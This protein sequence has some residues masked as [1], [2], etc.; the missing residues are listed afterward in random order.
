MS[1]DIQFEERNGLG[2]ITLT[3]PQALNALSLNMLESMTEHL[4]KWRDADHI[5]IVVIQADDGRAFCAGGD[6]RSLYQMGQDPEKRT[7]HY[8]WHEYRLNQL[9]GTYPKPYVSFLN[10]LT[11][12]GGVGIS[13]LGSF[14]I[15]TENLVFAMPETGIGFFPDIGST[16]LLSHCPDEIGTYLALTG[17]RLNAMDCQYC[18]LIEYHINS[19]DWSQILE[20]LPNATNLNALFAE[21][22]IP[23]NDASIA[24]FKAQIDQHFAFNSMVSIMGSLVDDPS[25][26]AQ[27]TLQT[28]QAKSP[29][30]LVATLKQIRYAERMDLGECLKM[31][32]RLVS[33]FIQGHDLYEGIRAQIID[34]DRSPKWQPGSVERVKNAEVD[35]Y[36]EPTPETELEFI[37]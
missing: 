1:N 23:C 36:F 35:I 6:I 8:F 29:T 13:L 22:Q 16:S 37:E 17:G 27:Q 19:A 14:P 15:G 20:A 28:L 3:R 9:I 31:D 11:M 34:K 12:G 24:E 4:I 5:K 21:F 25:E 10:G 33:H 32:Y 26:W 30:S 18:G 2:L 7:A